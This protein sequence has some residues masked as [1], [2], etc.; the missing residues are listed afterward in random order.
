[1]DPAESP[2]IPAPWDDSRRGL[3]AVTDGRLVGFGV[4][5]IVFGM[6]WAI[7]AQFKWRSAFVDGFAGYLSGAM[8]GQPH[9]VQRWIGFWIDVVGV[10]P[11]LFARIIAVCETLLALVLLLGVLTNLACVCGAMLSLTIWTIP[12]GFGGPYTAGA[13]DIGTGIIYVFVF[14]ALL[15]ASAGRYLGFDQYLGTKLGRWAFLASGPIRKPPNNV[16]AG[17]ESPEGDDRD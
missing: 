7:D 9:A 5:R 2:P 8:E 17:R 6:V 11:P 15:L 3:P 10:D 4:L 14:A 12:E 13:T 1:M 16:T